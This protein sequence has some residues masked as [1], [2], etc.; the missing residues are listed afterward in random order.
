V[1]DTAS[2]TTPYKARN[3]LTSFFFSFSF[4]HLSS[5]LFPSLFLFLYSLLSFFFSFLSFP[6]FPFWV[7]SQCC[8]RDEPKDSYMLSTSSTS[9]LPP[10]PVCYLLNINSILFCR[11]LPIL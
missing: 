11:F 3:W 8:A 4:F 2:T 10:T 6:F 7:G 5:S 1:L 9:E